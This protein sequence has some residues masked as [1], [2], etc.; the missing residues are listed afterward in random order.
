M[1]GVIIESID[2]QARPSQV[3]SHHPEPITRDNTS[4]KKW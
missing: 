2:K 4:D 3:L 1:M